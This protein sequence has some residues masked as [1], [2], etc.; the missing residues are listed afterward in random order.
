M[1][2]IS[3]KL[4]ISKK[5]LYRYVKSKEDLIEKLFELE[6]R[7]FIGSMERIGELKV[8]AIE[9]LFYVSEHYFEEIHRYKPIHLFEMR[10][11]YEPIFNHY[12][13]LR[14]GMITQYM[15]ENMELGIEEGLYRSELNVDAEVALYIRY[16]IDQHNSHEVCHDLNISYADLFKMMFEHHIR[17]IA[18][19]E[20]V[21]YF[22]KRKKEVTEVV[23]LNSNLNP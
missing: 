17:A 9:K 18:T 15:K 13:T 4:G 14:I 11:Y 23:H 20:G 21:G 10:K 5:T 19:L 2:D 12:Y 16:I 22:E 6:Y 1:D 7:R 8:N 3:R